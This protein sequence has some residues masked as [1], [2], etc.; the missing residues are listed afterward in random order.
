MAATVAIW[1]QFVGV[2]GG[3]EEGAKWSPYIPL[4][5]N[6]KLPELC[7]IPDFEFWPQKGIKYLTQL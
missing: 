7:S 3:R 2:Y 4:W 5:R 1:K 6:P